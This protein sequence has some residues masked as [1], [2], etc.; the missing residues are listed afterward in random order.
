MGGLPITL[1]A[2][3]AIIGQ[4]DPP[5]AELFED[6]TA[7]CGFGIRRILP[8]PTVGFYWTVD[9]FPQDATVLN[10][11]ISGRTTAP[12]VEPA[13]FQILEGPITG[14]VISGT[15]F[16]M[17]FSE[18]FVLETVQASGSPLLSKGQQY[19]FTISAGNI[20]REFNFIR[21]R[22]PDEP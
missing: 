18:S 22:L 20:Q 3:Q 12:L 16:N 13:A 9:D 14:P 5:S 21:I 6:E 10:F 7:L 8:P 1:S 11:D 19:T 15:F 2:C 4:L 17:I